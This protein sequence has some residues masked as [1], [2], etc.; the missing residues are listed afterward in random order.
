MHDV[1]LHQLSTVH[2]VVKIGLSQWNDHFVVATL[3]VRI[4]ACFYDV[5]L[6][7]VVF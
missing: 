2:D 7:I 4:A 3:P 6:E 5:G 1:E